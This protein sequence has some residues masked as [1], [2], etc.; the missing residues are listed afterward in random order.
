MVSWKF[1]A[2]AAVEQESAHYQVAPHSNLFNLCKSHDYLSSIS[3]KIC[4]K[5]ALAP[6][7]TRQILV[8]EALKWQILGRGALN[9]GD[10]TLN[11][12]PH[13]LVLQVSVHVHSPDA[14]FAHLRLCV[15]KSQTLLL[16]NGLIFEVSPNLEMP[17]IRREF[18][19][20]NP[21]GRVVN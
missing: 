12:L 20:T 17:H 2:M 18:S 7:E 4:W 10:V 1:K 16:C 8:R 21:A 9:M 13:R 3:L 14:F 6:L 15:A 5:S 11:C 19:G